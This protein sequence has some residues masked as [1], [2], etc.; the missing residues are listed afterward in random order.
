[1]LVLPVEIANSTSGVF[2]MDSFFL[3]ID[4]SATSTGLTLLSSQDYTSKNLLIKPGKLRDAARLH[5][6]STEIKTFIGDSSVAMCVH[7]SPSYGSTHKEFILGEVLGIVKLTLFELGITSIGVPPTQLKKYFTG[8]GR[9]SKQ[10][11]ISRAVELGCTSTQE[12]ICD[13]FAAAY[14]CKDL[15]QGPLLPTRPSREVRTAILNNM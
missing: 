15:K 14:L 4:P 12:D 2:A 13:S 11:M 10:D 7:E 1:M 6:I 3:G 9:A 8:K 5:Y